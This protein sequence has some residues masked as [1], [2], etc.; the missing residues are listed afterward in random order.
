MIKLFGFGERQTVEYLVVGLGNPGIKYESSRH[1]AGFMALDYI[2][3][4]LSS[5]VKRVKHFALVV[6]CTLGG[7]P[8]L[9]MKPQTYMNDSGKAVIDAARFYKIPPERIIVIFDDI[10]L[11]PGNIRIRAKGSAG[12][13]NGIKSIIEYLGSEN[14]MRIKIGVGAK[15]YPDMDLADWVLGKIPQEDMKKISSRFDDVMKAAELMTEGKISE[16]MNKY[17]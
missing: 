1:N 17:N 2:A 3:E 13:H 15:P 10:S 12:G 4:K 7:K 14:F 6:K 11:E 9:F 5:P 8:V 16:A